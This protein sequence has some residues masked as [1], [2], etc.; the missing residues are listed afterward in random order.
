MS[1][2][3]LFYSVVNNAR[4]N[5]Y[6]S[7]YSEITSLSFFTAQTF[8]HQIISNGGEWQPLRLVSGGG[9]KVYDMIYHHVDLSQISAHFE[10]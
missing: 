5:Y 10:R 8:R 6:H 9:K 1:L 4:R 3:L 2:I 7:I